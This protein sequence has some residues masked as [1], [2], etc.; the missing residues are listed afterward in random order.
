MASSNSKRA[1]SAIDDEIG[2]GHEAAFVR[3]QEQSCGSN[4]L[5]ATKAV[6]WGRSLEALPDRVGAFFR[7]CLRVDDGRVD[8]ARADR[9]DTNAAVLEFG[10]PR[11]HERANACLGRA[12]GGVTG[13]A[14]N[15]GD[16][17]NQDDGAPISK[18]RQRLLNRKEKA[19]Y[20][21]GEGPIEA[22]SP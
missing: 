17:R 1:Q 14:L 8:R 13:N 9:V 3:S 19:S 11:S 16:G 2:S 5:R 12:V 4:L 18:E 10:R 20:I 15:R 6:E 22:F 21:D 7:C